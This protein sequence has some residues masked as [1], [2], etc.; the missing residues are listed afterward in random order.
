M[1]VHQVGR[2]DEDLPDP[3]ATEVVNAAISLFAVA[4]PLQS[5][6]VQESV[7]E[8][9]A[10]F[11]TTSG[12]QRDAGRYA[13]ITANIVMALFS[14]LRVSMDETLAVAGDLRH[15][16]VVKTLAELL[17]VKTESRKQ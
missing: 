7:L 11:M 17:R 8:Q 13:A 10:T 9:L 4:L 3:P 16:S 5:P 12:S 15:P 1:T 14:T 6:R 2:G